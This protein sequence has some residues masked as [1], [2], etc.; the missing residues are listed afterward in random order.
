MN[1]PVGGEAVVQPP[2][3]GLA[4]AGSEDAA[5]ADGAA[6]LQLEGEYWRRE[7]AAR[8]ERYRT[9]RKPRPPRYPSLRL[10]FDSEEDRAV[11]PPSPEPSSPL[12]TA[13]LT[14]EPIGSMEFEPSFVSSPEP[15]HAPAA[16]PD[17][18]S[19]IIE[20][21]RSALAPPV[22]GN[23]LAET[24]IDRPRILEAP[25][26][27][28]P[29]PAMGGILIEPAANEQSQGRGT[30]DLP[31]PASLGRRVLAGFVDGVVLA[32]GIG[33]FAGFFLWVNTD[34]PSLASAIAGSLAL[35]AVLWAVYKFLFIVY[36]GSTPGM[37]LTRLR[38]QHAD[39]SPVQRKVRRWRVMASYLSALSLGLGYFWSFLDEDDL[40]WHDRMTRTC[41]R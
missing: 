8:L 13:A 38:L 9:R 24:L 19:N 21:P 33:T 14:P 22:R 31:R 20:F 32:A 12:A 30:V 2:D 34:L 7:V 10:P 28:P 25:E 3:P 17:R 26:I 1:C 36:A 11:R 29:P 41:L 18:Y 4:Q 5:N 27:I 16:E 40:C 37:R 23:E 15:V 39:G 6:E 35:W